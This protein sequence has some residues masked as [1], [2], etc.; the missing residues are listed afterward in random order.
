[1]DVYLDFLDQLPRFI[2]NPADPPN[3]SN[4]LSDEPFCVTEKLSD[5][6]IGALL[7]CI[8]AK[9]NLE[10]LHLNNNLSKSLDGH[11]LEPLRGSVVLK[12][13]IFDEQSEMSLPTV[14]PILES[15]VDVDGNS[16][17]RLELPNEWKKGKV[18]GESPLNDFLQKFTELILSEEVE[19][20][21]CKNKVTHDPEGWETRIDTC[22]TCFKFICNTCKETEYPNIFYK[23]AITVV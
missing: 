19:C 4:I 9:N 20:A 1:M 13:I 17:R 22:Y 2:I 16:L 5:D 14:I 7:V 21:Q 23:G 15:I 10:H 8:D 12:S 6:D 18:R 11:C 3:H